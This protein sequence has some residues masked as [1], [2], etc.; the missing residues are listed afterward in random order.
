[1]RARRV[2]ADLARGVL[3]I[4]KAVALTVLFA[5]PIL[6]AVSGTPDGRSMADRYQRALQ[7]ELSAHHCLPPALPGQRLASHDLPRS[8]LIRTPTGRLRH[9]T[10]AR[11]WSAYRGHAPGT[12]IAVCTDR[13]SRR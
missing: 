12:L 10:F 3:I 9:V 8:A 1:M 4:V 2:P 5:V 13:V 11:G 6:H 7:A